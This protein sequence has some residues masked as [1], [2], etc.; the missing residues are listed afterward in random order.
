MQ[1]PEKNSINAD[2]QTAQNRMFAFVEK[3]IRE[4][5]KQGTIHDLLNSPQ[6]QKKL[7]VNVRNSLFDLLK[8]PDGERP[9]GKRDAWYMGIGD[10]GKRTIELIVNFFCPKNNGEN[11]VVNTENYVAFNKF[12]AAV[13]LKNQNGVEFEKPFDL[14][15]GKALTVNS[16]IELEKAK[17]MIKSNQIKTLWVAWNSTSTG[18][19]ENVEKLVEFRNLCN[20]DTLIVAD[21][22][23]LRLFTKDWETLLTD[24]RPDVFFFS[25]RKQG[26]PYEGPQDEFNQAKNSGSVFIFNKKAKD[27]A[28]EIDAGPIYESPNVSDIAEGEITQGRQKENHIKHLLKLR[29]T[30]EHFLKND[31][32]ELKTADKMRAL[33]GS[34]IVTAFSKHGEL[35]RLRF[36]LLADPVVQSASSYVIQVPENIKTIEM[37]SWL[38]GRGVGISVSKHPCVDSKK[39]VRF[40]FYPGNTPEEVQTMI[41]EI[42]NYVTI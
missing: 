3:K 38:K 40:A 39:Y 10:S 27:R 4:L 7:F 25:L 14:Q 6:E 9:E 32:N 29:E 13:A 2:L 5:E 23:S 12:S 16:V 41:S 22:A 31:G 36:S 37:V 8:I 35:E 21:A 28:R 42:A 30:C 11:I 1:S 26:I 24:N 18:V 15:L 20:S 19:Q 17:E 34:K 33:A